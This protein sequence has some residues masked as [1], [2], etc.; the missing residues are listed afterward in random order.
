MKK[1]LVLAKTGM[2]GS[3]VYN[4]FKNS[5]FEVFGTTRNELDAQLS[6]E[7][8]IEKVISGFDYVINCIGII[9]PYIHP[10][11]TSPSYPFD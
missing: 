3:A 4:K 11:V 9:K 2:L 6:T 1:I 5:E 7:V 10:K 8:E